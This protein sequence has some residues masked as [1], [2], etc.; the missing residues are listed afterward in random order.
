MRLPRQFFIVAGSA[1]IIASIAVA[2][3][4]FSLVPSATATVGEPTPDPCQDQTTSYN[5]GAA[6]GPEL[7]AF[8]AQCETPTEGP[9]K[10][11]TPTPQGTAV[12]TEEPE[13]TNTAPAAPTTAPATSTPSGSAG[14][15][16][17]TPP[18][19]GTGGDASASDQWLIA[20]GSVLLLLGGAGTIGYG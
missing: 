16:G 2:G 11:H 4:S 12:P 15:G 3:L 6:P 20:A 8:G 13:A 9:P 5:G 19:T 10:T 18:N 14:S 17:V 1:A 7:V